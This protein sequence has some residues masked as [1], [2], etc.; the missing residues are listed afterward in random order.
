MS[1]QQKPMIEIYTE[2]TPN[3]ESLK[4]VVN[5]MLLMNTNADFKDAEAAKRSPLAEDLFAQPFVKRVFISANFV[6]V[7]KDGE[8]EWI[9][10]IPQIKDIVKSF[11]ASER[12]VLLVPE[13][14]VA[15][16]IGA[17]AGSVEEKIIQTLDTYVRPAVEMDGGNIKFKSF[18]EGVVTLILQGSCS[19]CPSSTM[20]LKAGIEGLLQRM[21]PEVKEVVAEQEAV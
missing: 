9:E 19:G 2:Y 1:V 6:T 13:G 16:D 15:S 3:P 20:T 14:S 21:V 17:D 10:I 18:E 11:I 5:K 7:T 12:E 4:F 8:A